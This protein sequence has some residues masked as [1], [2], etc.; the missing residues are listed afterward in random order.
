[1]DYYHNPHEFAAN[2]ILSNINS[3]ITIQQNDFIVNN[4]NIDI[5]VGIDF[6]LLK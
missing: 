5:S 3:I 2:P 1:M 4:G 6:D